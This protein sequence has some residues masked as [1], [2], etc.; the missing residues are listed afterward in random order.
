[1]G[2]H[3]EGRYNRI[4]LNKGK[5]QPKRSITGPFTFAVNDCLHDLRLAVDKLVNLRERPFFPHFV[6]GET[7]DSRQEVPS[8]APPFQKKVVCQIVVVFWSQTEKF[9]P[10][11]GCF[12]WKYLIIRKKLFPL[13]ESS[14][15]LNTSGNFTLFGFIVMMIDYSH[16]LY[17][18]AQL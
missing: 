10:S 11:G 6:D 9:L 3:A 1:M 15:F 12:F 7:G 16:Q 17:I 13:S 18:S 5:I 8:L 2:L 4:K 14:L